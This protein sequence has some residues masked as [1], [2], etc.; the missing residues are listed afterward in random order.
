MDLDQQLGT[1]CFRPSSGHRKVHTIL[2]EASHCLA[3]FRQASTQHSGT[4]RPDSWSRNVSCRSSSVKLTPTRDLP[5]F[6]Q[7]YLGPMAPYSG[8]FRCVMWTWTWPWL[9]SSHCAHVDTSQAHLCILIVFH[10]EP[11]GIWRVAVGYSKMGCGPGSYS[12][13][14]NLQPCMCFMTFDAVV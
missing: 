1:F 14:F 7:W 11:F 2:A 5:D 4:G 6:C 9:T 10:G 12:N 3:W 8:G 13:S